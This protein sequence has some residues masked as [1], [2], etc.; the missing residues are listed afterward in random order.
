MEIIAITIT[1]LLAAI[2][3]FMAGRL[4]FHE[5]DIYEEGWDDGWKAC[6]ELSNPD[7]VIEPLATRKGGSD[8]QE[9]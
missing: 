1:T 6:A 7:S 9:S 8:E 3:G 4:T 5:A 2:A